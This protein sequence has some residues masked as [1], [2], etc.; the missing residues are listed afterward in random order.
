MSRIMARTLM[1]STVAGLIAFAAGCSGTAGQQRTA[2]GVEAIRDLRDAVQQNSKQIDLVL[3]ALDK[4]VGSANTDPTP[5]YM[6]FRSQLTTLDSDTE[7][8]RSRAATM[9]TRTEEYIRSWEAELVN[10]Q[11]PEVQKQSDERRGQARESFAK[12][13]SSS[14][15]VRDT[16]KQF[17]GDLHDIQSYL[18]N[19]LNARGLAAITT[20]VDKTKAEGKAIQDGL[21][22]FSTQL[23]DVANA[24]APKAEVTTAEAQKT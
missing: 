3:G 21:S 16:Y 14:Q 4:V 18:D 10:I 17:Q 2:G 9:K 19:D 15:S 12:L 23:N 13:Q 7:K 11:N 5:A 22:A 20:L 6:E 1:A 24:I 8:A